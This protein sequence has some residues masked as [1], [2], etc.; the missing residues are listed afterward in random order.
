MQYPAQSN[1]PAS[2]VFEEIGCFRKTNSRVA[3][4]DP[5][6][7]TIQASLYMNI[8]P[9]INRLESIF[10]NRRHAHNCKTRINKYD[11]PTDSYSS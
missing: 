5:K 10:R 11:F 8:K 4:S 3:E 6:T 2:D 7:N 1:H 9:D